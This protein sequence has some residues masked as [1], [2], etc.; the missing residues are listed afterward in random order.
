MEYLIQNIIIRSTQAGQSGTNLENEEIQDSQ[1]DAAGESQNPTSEIKDLVLAGYYDGN[2]KIMRIRQDGSIVNE[3]TKAFDLDGDAGTTIANLGHDYFR[4]VKCSTNGDVYLAGVFK[5]PLHA[6]DRNTILKKFDK[7]G[8]AMPGWDKKIELY[9]EFD[10]P[11]T[12]TF[13]QNENIYLSTRNS[14]ATFV[15][16]GRIFKY[17]PDGTE[18]GAPWSIVIPAVSAHNFCGGV[19]VDSSGNIFAGCVY[20]SATSSTGGNNVWWIRK[21][22][23]NVNEDMANF[24]IRIANPL[25][26]TGGWHNLPYTSILDN[27]ENFIVAG[28]MK[29][30]GTIDNDAWY[31]RKFNK[32]TGAIIWTHSWDIKTNLN[33]DSEIARS[34]TVD[35]DNNTYVVGSLNSNNGDAAKSRWG[36]KKLDTSGNEIPGWTKIFESPTAGADGSS[37]PLIVKIG[38]DGKIYIAG[39][40]GTGTGITG[41]KGIV[42]RFHPDGTEDTSFNPGILDIA[43]YGMDLCVP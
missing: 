5:G 39:F 32:D 9:N 4:N 22:D 20:Y 21:W 40:W 33:N 23:S 36:I 24:D 27:D 13:D 2:S 11:W 16:E 10:D 41:R 17:Q 8:V 42:M 15:G 43:I 6:L 12:L 30:P 26:N 25:G 28:H 29:S 18:F 7:S 38:E 14:N 34:M 35:A 31:I 3:W 1:G 19:S 37:I